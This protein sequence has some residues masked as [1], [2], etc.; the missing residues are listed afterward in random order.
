MTEGQIF[1]YCYANV[2][3]CEN[4]IAMTNY[5]LDNN[6]QG[7]FIECGVAA[8]GQISL[9]KKTLGHK[10]QIRKIVAF[11]SFDG[12]PYGIEGK[13]T[14]QAGI[15]W[16]PDMDGRLVSTGITRHTLANCIGNIKDCTGNVDNIEFIAGWFQDTLPKYKPNDIALLR[17][18]GDLYESTLVCLKY[19]FKSVV[20]GGV[21]IVD[22]YGL[23]GCKLACDEYFKKI[24]YKPNYQ[25]IKDSTAVYFI[26]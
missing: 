10:G 25:T 16:I 14:E 15:G 17:L 13:D 9:M 3:T 1:Q 7:D 8:G 12:I 4:T 23:T 11:D 20:K 5:V 21:V 24:K 2:T 19:L 22:D 18:D 26:K 6:I